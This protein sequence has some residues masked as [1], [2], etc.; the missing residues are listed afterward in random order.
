MTQ[1]PNNVPTQLQIN[2]PPEAEA[3][4]FANFAGVWNDN[5]SFILDFAAITQA[6]QLATRDDGTQVANVRARIVSRVRV[7][8]RQALE[9]M[10]ALNEQLGHWESAHGPVA[11]PPPDET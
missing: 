1:P 4:V 7:P 3:G 10:R 6:P 2:L 8:P 5:D 11:G 9:L